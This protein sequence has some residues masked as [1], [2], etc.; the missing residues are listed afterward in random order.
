[1]LRIKEISSRTRKHYKDDEINYFRSSITV[2]E[3]V[4]ETSIEEN[5]HGFGQR[6]E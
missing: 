5:Q 1:M 3:R 2:R 4:C 6:W